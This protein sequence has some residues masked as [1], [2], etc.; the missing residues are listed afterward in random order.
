MTLSVNRSVLRIVQRM[1]DGRDEL[2]L[3]VEETGGGATLID[4]GVD[5]QGGYAAG[6]CL[7]EACMGG[8]GSASLGMADFG[9]LTLP[10]VTVNTDF[11]SAALFAAQYAGWRI[12]SGEGYFAMGSGP[13]R[14]LA[15][16]PKE[17]YAKIGYRDEAD[18]ATLVL[19]ASAK[20]PKEVIDQVA[21]ECRVAPEKLYVMVAPTSS[22]AGSTQIS[23]RVA[24]TGLHK[25]VEVGLDP[26]VVV[27]A[28]GCAPVAPVHPK[29][30]RAMG[31]TNDMILYGGVAFF[32]VVCD[33]AVLREVVERAPS[34]MSR[35]YGRPFA[36]VFKDAGY[37]FYKIDAALFAPA[38]VVV[39]NVKSGK[40]FKAG[41][42]NAEILK[43]SIES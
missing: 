43:Q 21:R 19:E 28:V 34:S 29:S 22:V 36:D 3:G 20:P 39:N 2:K 18:T 16:K 32:N 13:A 25:L 8:L 17:L 15:L 12:S 14:A 26:R 9:D 31:R 10:V 38:V 41:K 23:G 40:V 24:E 1:L 11:P 7:T 37:D 5:A 6:I 35:D 30:N 42:I 33:D 4:A 27:S